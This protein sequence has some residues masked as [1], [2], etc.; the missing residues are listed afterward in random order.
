MTLL[1]ICENAAD[2]IGINRPPT[3][4]GN[5]APDAQKLLG[6]CNMVGLSLMKQVAWQVIRKEQTFTAI[7]GATQTGILPS[8]FD[9]FVPETMWDRTNIHLVSGPISAVEWQGLKAGQY[10]DTSRPKFIYRGG[11][12]LVIPSFSGGESI[13]FE[14]VSNKWAQDNS[15][16]A[17]TSF[18]ADTDTALLDEELITRGVVFRFLDGEGLPTAQAANDYQTYFDMV[19]GND[20]PTAGIMVAADIFGGGRH[21]AG[22]PPADGSGSTL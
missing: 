7:A 21:F 22:A 5:T 13:A 6:Y 14:Y 2:R 10:Q 12:V 17:K 8:D 19:L 3:V 16:V 11:S 15:S 9:R 1:T 20:Q 4:V 18:T